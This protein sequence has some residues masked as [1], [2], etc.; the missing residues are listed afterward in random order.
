MAVILKCA[1][2]SPQKQRDLNLDH[3][4]RLNKPNGI[5][6]LMGHKNQN[7]MPFK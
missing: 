5:C 1:Q 7:Y 6:T 4:F 3:D 2:Q